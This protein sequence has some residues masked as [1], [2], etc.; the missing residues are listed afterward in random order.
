MA[1]TLQAILTLKDDFSA[2]MRG[3]GGTT[4]EALGMALVGANKLIPA[5]QSGFSLLT[6]DYSQLGNMLGALPG[7][8]GAIGS[9]I[10]STLGKAIDDT[11]QYAEAMRKAS[12]ATGASVEFISQFTE[13]SDDLFIKQETVTASL[14]RF[15]KGL[16]GAM[17]AE[18]AFAT[19]GKGVV[20]VLAD[21]GINANDAAGK[22]KPLEVL[23]PELADKFHAMGPGVESS[24]LAVKL[25]GKQ[26]QELLPVL[27]QGREAMEGA[28]HAARDMGLAIDQNAVD[29][30][31]RL[32]Q[33]QDTLGD[34][35]TSLG[36]KISLAVI[37][38]LADVTTGLNLYFEN[39]S[40]IQQNG[41]FFERTLQSA[42]NAI[43]FLTGNLK[44]AAEEAK[45]TADATQD[46]GDATKTAAEQ[47]KA[48]ADAAKAEAEAEKELQASINN[49]EKALSGKSEA[50]TKAQLAQEA[51]KLATGQSTVAAFEQEQAAKALMN[52]YMDNTL[53]L[54][55]LTAAEADLARGNLTAQQAFE[56][57]GAAAKQNQADMRTVEAAANGVSSA[58]RAIPKDTTVTVRGNVDGSMN[59]ARSTYDSIHDK[60]VTVTVNYSIP[61]GQINIPG[62]GRC[63]VAG[64]PISTPRGDIPIDYLFVGDKV[65]S[66]D[67]EQG[68][69]TLA[70][71]SKTFVTERAETIVIK[72][73]GDV[74]IRC[75]PRHPF[76]C[77]GEYIPAEHLKPGDVLFAPDDGVAHVLWTHTAGPETVYNIEVEGY[78]NYYAGGVLVHNLSIHADTFPTQAPGVQMAAVNMPVTIAGVNMRQVQNQLDRAARLARL[79]AS[80]GS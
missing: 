13:A 36:R 6:G 15:A 52:A 34:S 19:G 40:K 16:G 59:A 53:T 38:P 24:A 77:R 71:V 44:P 8:L 22:A 55:Q 60:T 48:A 57:S 21:M 14:N 31:T 30:V 68:R 1:I 54:G 20:A 72:L 27:L 32:K 70:T 10:G 65:W 74:S 47:A 63:F 26:G 4:S 9:T 78:H 3:I 33:A 62:G 69:T 37:P 79:R 51:Y 17:D 76:Y 23:I 49:V 50:L 46:L 41:N 73:T 42:G 58:V 2:K 11:V 64:T 28:M 5:V 66:Y 75:T 35:A 56:M 39:V 45:K 12:A 18:G 25:F 43:D 67:H 80:T 61:A 29:A 7:P